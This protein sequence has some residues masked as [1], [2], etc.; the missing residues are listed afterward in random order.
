[1]NRLRSIMTD[2]TPAIP[3]AQVDLDPDRI[4]NGISHSMARA[5]NH[6][7]RYLRDYAKSDADITSNTY[8]AEAE[9]ALSSDLA[10]LRAQKMTGMARIKQGWAEMRIHWRVGISQCH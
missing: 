2:L 9:E 4:P 7:V 3:L 5:S 1:M 10:F 6:A 8:I